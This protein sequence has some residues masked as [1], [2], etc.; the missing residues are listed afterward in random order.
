MFS[1]RSQ[2]G[3]NYEIHYTA[4]A[5]GSLRITGSGSGKMRQGTLTGRF[6]ENL[7]N[8]TQCSGTFISQ[9]QEG[10]PSK[11][12]IEFFITGGKGCTQVGETAS[13]KLT[14]F[15]GTMYNSMR[16]LH[17]P[18]NKPLERLNIRA[19]PN[20][21]LLGYGLSGDIAWYKAREGD[22]LLVRVGDLTGWIHTS[23]VLSY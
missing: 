17:D 13:V 9:Y 5:G 16:V 10:Y 23:L 11:H 20:G 14:E 2:D 7:S 19:S 18:A 21:K 3:V 15:A 8:G 6:T 12:E 22:W 4:K 1:F